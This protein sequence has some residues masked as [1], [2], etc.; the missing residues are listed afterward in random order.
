MLKEKV[1]RFDQKTIEHLNYYVYALIDPESNQPF[2]IGKGKENRIFDHISCALAY[3]TI[4]D[5]YD[6]IRE[7]SK[8]NLEVKHVIIRHDLSDE[9]AL[10]IESSLI[11]FLQYLEF[12]ITN[13]VLGHH[14]LDRGVMTS[15][16][17]IRRY[18]AK[19]LTEITDPLIIININ[20]TYKRG[21]GQDGIY[22]A[23]KESWALDKNKIKL[24]KY[25]LSEYRGLIVEVFKIAKWYPVDTVDKNGKPKVR[26]G[27]NGEIANDDVRNK[28]I[29]KSVAH[30]KKRGSSNP[31]RYKL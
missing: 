28:Y 23:T 2:Y 19:E 20:K 4:N 26:W 16:E 5:K 9:E 22:K 27:F 3:E 6:K 30:I 21:S 17:I 7:I 8:K 13:E 25:A 29:N 31:I 10:E 11:D 24:I 14:T 12:D 15:D 1:M 18:N